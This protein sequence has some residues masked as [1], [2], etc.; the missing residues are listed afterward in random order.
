MAVPVS[1]GGGPVGVVA[2]AFKVM[3][4]PDITVILGVAEPEDDE[5]EPEAVVVVVVCGAPGT[6]GNGGVVVGCGG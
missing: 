2:V 1:N 4:M 3:V 5:P 6:L